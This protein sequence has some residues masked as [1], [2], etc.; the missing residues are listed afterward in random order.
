MKKHRRKR[1][2]FLGGF[3]GADSMIEWIEANPLPEVCQKCEELQ[4]TY[5]AATEEKQIEM[6][7]SGFLFDCGSCENAG[8]RWYLSRLDELKLT[9][10]S[11]LKAI[12]RNKGQIEE[13]QRRLDGVNKELADIVESMV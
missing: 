2:A 8:A 4:K 9:R 13:Y 6:E 10:K 11:L 1:K 5:L 3:S 12:D 7:E